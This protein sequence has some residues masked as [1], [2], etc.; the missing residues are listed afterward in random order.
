MYSFAGLSDGAVPVAGLTELNGE[1]Y[2]TTQYG[3]TGPGGGTVFKSPPPEGKASSI[4]SARL[5]VTAQTTRR[6]RRSIIRTG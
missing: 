5:E 6:R 3:R 2:G 4:D 1:L